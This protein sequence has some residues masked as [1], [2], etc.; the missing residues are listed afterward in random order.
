MGVPEAEGGLWGTMGGGA[1]WVGGQ[2]GTGKM[3]LQMGLMGL[4]PNP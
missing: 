2:H 3:G 1:G 4:G